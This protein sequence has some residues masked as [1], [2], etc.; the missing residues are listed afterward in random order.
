MCNGCWDL[1]S[2]E[3]EGCWVRARNAI[4]EKERPECPSILRNASGGLDGA[5]DTHLRQYLP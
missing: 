5:R 1:V 2:E 3:E 4:E